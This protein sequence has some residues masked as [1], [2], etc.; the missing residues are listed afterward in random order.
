MLFRDRHEVL[1]MFCTH[2][3]DA[4]IVHAKREAD[5]TCGVRPETEGKFALLI[6]L[7]V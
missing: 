2:T 6:P 5:W 4:K 3:F 7:F 1:H